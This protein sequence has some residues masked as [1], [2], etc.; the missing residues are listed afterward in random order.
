MASTRQLRITV[1][2]QGSASVAT[3]MTASPFCK[4]ESAEAACG[5]HLCRSG[6]PP[7]GLSFQ[8]PRAAGWHHWVLLFVPHS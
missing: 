2:R 4:S 3:I 7:P 8:R 6:C 1:E 5:N